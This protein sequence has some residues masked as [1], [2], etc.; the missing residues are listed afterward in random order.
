MSSD[1]RPKIF[2]ISTKIIIKVE[3]VLH[4]MA[5]VSLLVIAGSITAD[6]ISRLLF[7]EPFHL[8]FELTEMY[9]MPAVAVLSVSYV[10]REGG[11]LSLDIIPTE[12]FGRAW[13]SVCL[14]VLAI[15]A[16]FIGLLA[17]KSG[18]Y[19]FDAWTRG[20]TY[21]GVYDMSLALAYS[22]VPL[23]CGTLA[24]RL[25]HDF[26]DTLIWNNNEEIR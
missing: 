11:H 10:Y 24:V 25:V 3:N 26:L 5:C 15:S 18:G 14:L 2:N 16:L 12:L 4:L 13:K 8:Q 23:G 22:V 6:I 7:N 17:W 20:D 1:V 21:Y 19:A 9:L